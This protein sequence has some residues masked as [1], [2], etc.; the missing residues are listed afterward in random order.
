M[1]WTILFLSTFALGRVVDNPGQL[2][3]VPGDGPRVPGNSL[4]VQCPESNRSDLLAISRLQNKPQIP[5]LNEEIDVLIWGAFARNISALSTVR[6]WINATANNGESGSINGTFHIC[7]YLEMM[8]RP[9]SDDERVVQCP[10]SQGPIYIDYAMWFADILVAPGLW[11]VKFD[12]KTPE[13]DRIY[14]L[15]TEFDLQCKPDHE[16]PECMRDANGSIQDRLA[17]TNF[18]RQL[19]SV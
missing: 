19:I 17:A 10:P 16:G 7:S 12:A 1:I 6:Y 4:V 14:C 15:Q 2:P 11:S 9:G 18:G 8:Q 3:L 5:Y 13:G